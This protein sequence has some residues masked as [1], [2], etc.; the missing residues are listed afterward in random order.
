MSYRFK[1]PK[2][3]IE[4]QENLIVP[5]SL[6]VSPSDGYFA[7]DNSDN[8]FKVWSTAKNRWIILGDAS[9]VVFDNSSNGFSSTDTQSAIEEA[10]NFPKI[11]YFYQSATGETQTTSTNDITLNG[12]TVTPT[13]AGTYVIIGYAAVTTFALLGHIEYFSL[14][15]NNS[16]ISNTAQEIYVSNQSRPSA[17]C[18]LMSVSTANGTSDSFS[19]KW[20][21]QN[22]TGRAFGRYILVFRVN[23]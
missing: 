4:G 16:Q 3:I 7:I 20:K 17:M 14:Y 21:V 10:Q 13:T 23:S 2:V 8:K 9:D 5:S 19:I 6:P 22:S 1:G 12:M 18:S 15:K 11:K